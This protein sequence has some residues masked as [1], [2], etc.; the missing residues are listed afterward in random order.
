LYTVI[1]EG[2]IAKKYFSHWLLQGGDEGVL[3]F[4]GKQ[5]INANEWFK[6][7]IN[8][9]KNRKVNESGL[10]NKTYIQIPAYQERILIIEDQYPKIIEFARKN[11]WEE[12]KGLTQEQIKILG[13][14]I[15]N[16]LDLSSI[17]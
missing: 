12:G 6:I 5:Q 17:I 3:F 4:N 9:V 15:I 7:A 13:N 2:I 11:G 16:E 8:S 1:L 10:Q 14:K